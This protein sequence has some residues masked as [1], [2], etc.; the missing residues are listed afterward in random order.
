MAETTGTIDTQ[1]VTETMEATATAG[2][3]SK[4]QETVGSFRAY[5]SLQPHR[6]PATVAAR[7]LEIAANAHVPVPEGLLAVATPKIHGS[8]LQMHYAPSSGLRYGRR[9]AF[10]STGETHYGAVGV[11]A[12]L[13]L[14]TKLAAL[15]DGL[16]LAHAGLQSVTVYGEVYG[17]W[18]PHPDV[19][20]AKPRQKHVQKGVWYDP[21][22]RI[23]AF[24]VQM[25][26]NNRSSFLGYDDA[27]FACMHVGI[28]FIPEAKRGPV[29]DVC[30][31]ATAHAGDCA[32]DFYN[33]SGLPA[34]A[35]NGGE[36]F[37]VRLVS[38]VCWEGER[39]LSKVKNPSFQEVAEGKKDEDPEEPK[40]KKEE[41]PATL[42]ALKYLNL[43]RMTAVASK[44]GEAEVHPKNLRLMA[45]AMTADARAE[46][47]MSDEE[48]VAIAVGSSGARIFTARAF[49]VAKEFLTGR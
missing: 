17:G 39:A 36:G 11:G 48:R 13:D 30:E 25:V 18:Y 21:Y 12:A 31:W 38:E 15:F 10:L 29:L 9:S 20:P 5:P 7:L 26:T 44:M 8:N 46:T 4:A 49:T 16:A 1:A 42:V 34:L 45:N 22:V 33:P 6:G 14:P 37:V 2:A 23:V 24:D 27:R 28:P 41:D 40:D 47:I 3:G 35:N 43:N 32:T 19:T